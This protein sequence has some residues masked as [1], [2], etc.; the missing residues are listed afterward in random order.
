VVWLIGWLLTWAWDIK[1]ESEHPA[2]YSVVLPTGESRF[3]SRLFVEQ[4][5]DHGMVM[6]LV[7]PGVVYVE[8]G[9]GMGWICNSAQVGRC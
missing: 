3:N 4:M 1:G 7:W 6:L 9:Q 5:I 8:V 2:A